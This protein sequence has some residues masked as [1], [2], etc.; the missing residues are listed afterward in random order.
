MRPN[1]AARPEYVAAFSEI[2]GRIA[3]PLSGTAEARVNAVEVEVLDP[4]GAVD[5]H[6]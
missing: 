6:L 2:A 5:Q 3:R 1:R 4:D